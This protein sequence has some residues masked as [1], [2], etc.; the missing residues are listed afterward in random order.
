MGKTEQE[1]GMTKANA[2]VIVMGDIHSQVMKSGAHRRQR[3]G[4]KESRAALKQNQ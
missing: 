3:K 4:E 2:Q 1:K